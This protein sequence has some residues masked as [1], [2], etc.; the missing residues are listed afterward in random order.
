MVKILY[1]KWGVST[2]YKEKSR[3]LSGTRGRRMEQ[4]IF[5]VSLGVKGQF[6]AL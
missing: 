4:A 5:E 6:C 1:K 2:R 3:Q